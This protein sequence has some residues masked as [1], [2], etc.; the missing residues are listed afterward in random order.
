MALGTALVV[1]ATLFGGAVK[2]YGNIKANAAFYREQAEFAREATNRTL[3]IYQDDTDT[4]VGQQKTSIAKSGISLSGSALLALADTKFKS[5]REEEAI[6][7]DG[8]FKEQEALLKAGASI[9]QADRIS[10]FSNNALPAFGT[11][12]NT[13]VSIYK[14][15]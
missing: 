11:A 4:F 15:L 13:G 1:G 7:R 9:D 8:K 3:E 2:A 12:I 5:L 10:S 14:G 6:L